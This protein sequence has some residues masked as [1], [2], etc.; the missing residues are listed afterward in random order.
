[1]LFKRFITSAVFIFIAL[2]YGC[3]G[4]EDS[5]FE[6]GIDG[7]G[8][9]HSSS[10]SIN[11]FG[12]VIVNGIHYDTNGA[13]FF[14]SGTA[15]NDS[16]LSVGDYVTVLGTLDSNGTTGTAEQVIYQ[17][18]V[19]GTIESIN[20]LDNS[21]VVLGQTVQLNA[22]TIFSANIVQRSASGLNTG[23]T[24]QVSG[25]AD[26]NGTI[27][28]S[29]LDKFEQ[30]N[31]ELMGSISN[32]DTMTNTLSINGQQVDYS[33]ATISMED[34]NQLQNGLI[35]IA[36]GTT[37]QDD[38]FIAQ[39]LSI[40]SNNFDLLETS[41]S[42][43]LS[44]IID[45]FDNAQTFRIANTEL[46]VNNSTQYNGGTSADLA[47][48][49]QVHVTGNINSENIVI[50]ESL[51]FITEADTV[52]FGEVS[53]LSRTR[54]DGINSGQIGIDGQLY[55]TTSSTH[56][57][58]YLE[59]SSVDFGITNIIL[60]DLVTITAKEIDGQFFAEVVEREDAGGPIS[61]ELRGPENNLTENGMQLYDYDIVFDE[62]TTFI[63]DDNFVDVQSFVA[64]AT[65]GLVEMQGQSLDGVITASS[66]KLLVNF[67]SL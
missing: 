67:P 46:R 23:E 49:A 33:T 6:G 20:V 56:F 4:G 27:N 62:Q 53:T 31:I 40:A 11:G 19:T 57:I 61:I 60:G 2:A 48:N 65:G 38:T 22:T 3:G 16:D 17:P 43:E 58:D 55:E 51:T 24:V 5:T 26:S 59:N 12:S 10:G 1:M 29:R 14:V 47:L 15:A 37:I 34:A 30:S 21:L 32:L 63:I 66:V 18:R 35:V 28:A 54:E 39:S 41:A 42:I 64:Q 44:G 52:V 50:V 8:Y 36:R 25:P 45:F 9:T 7:S 13:E